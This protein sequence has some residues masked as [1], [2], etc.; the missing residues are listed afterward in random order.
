MD[1]MSDHRLLP[2][3][4]IYGVTGTSVREVTLIGMCAPRCGTR[5]EAGYKR[6]WED[7]EEYPEH[8]A[9]VLEPALSERL[10]VM[11]GY[12]QNTVKWV[13][14]CPACL[15]RNDPGICRREAG[16]IL[17]CRRNGIF[18]ITTVQA[19]TDAGPAGTKEVPRS[20]DP[21]D[22]A[23]RFAPAAVPAQQCMLGLVLLPGWSS[24]GAKPQTSVASNHSSCCMRRF[25]ISHASPGP[26]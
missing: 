17:P 2:G 26:T 4:C 15:G 11:G 24:S 21:A 9:G 25:A 23:M 10:V 1:S 6:K 7:H 18:P 20:V 3:R 12:N 14:G 16:G 13:D 19:G 5:V 8:H 22:Q